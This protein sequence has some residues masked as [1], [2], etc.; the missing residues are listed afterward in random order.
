MCCSQ[1]YGCHSDYISN[2]A[3]RLLLFEYLN[4]NEAFVTVTELLLFFN[5]PAL[6]IMCLSPFPPL[7]FCT[8]LDD[9]RWNRGVVTVETAEEE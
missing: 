3:D 1:I 9:R 7:W 8:I 2:R 4:S 5:P 6:Q